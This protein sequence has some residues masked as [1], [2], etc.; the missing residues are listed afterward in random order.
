MTNTAQALQ[1]FFGGFGPPAFTEYDVPDMMPDEHGVMHKVELPYITYQLVEPDWRG[2]A[3]MYA[4]VWT[5]STSYAQ[6]AAIVD[7]IRA[8]VGDGIS[9]PTENGAVWLF[10]GS[11]FAQNM[12]MEGDDTLKVVYLNFMIHALT[13]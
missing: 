11:P 8:A 7:Q 6:V 12:P 10:K 3:T 2:Y 9:L 5:R 4:R 13:D 1:A